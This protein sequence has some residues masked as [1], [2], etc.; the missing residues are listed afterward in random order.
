LTRKLSV[1][2]CVFRAPLHSTYIIILFSIINFGQYPFEK[3][4]SP[5]YKSLNIRLKTECI[6][7]FKD[8]YFIFFKGKPNLVTVNGNVGTK[9]ETYIQVKP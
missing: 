2:L 7:I 6:R 1:S 9:K 8:Y 3:F 5:K 4:K